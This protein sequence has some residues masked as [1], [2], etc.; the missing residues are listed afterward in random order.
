MYSVFI[1]LHFCV[2][3]SVIRQLGDCGGVR[4]P[5]LHWLTWKCGVDLLSGDGLRDDYCYRSQSCLRYGNTLDEFKRSC[6]CLPLLMPMARS[7][8][9]EL[10]SFPPMSVIFSLLTV[11]SSKARPSSPF[12]H[13]KQHIFGTFLE[14]L[15]TAVS[16]GPLH[17]RQL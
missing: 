5:S 10:C 7:L 13:F 6:L 15:N 12:Q 4:S 11:V 16:S 14:K 17:Q 2:C 1:T 8:W 9:R 3:I